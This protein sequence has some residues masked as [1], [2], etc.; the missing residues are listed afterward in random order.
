MILICKSLRFV[1][2]NSMHKNGETLNFV[3]TK[4]LSDHAVIKMPELTECFLIDLV[5]TVL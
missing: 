4:I 3:P 1:I 2:L 5:L